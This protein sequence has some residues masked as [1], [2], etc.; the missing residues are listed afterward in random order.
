MTKLLRKIKCPSVFFCLTTIAALCL[1]LPDHTVEHLAANTR[2]FT[3]HHY[4]LGILHLITYQFMHANLDHFKYNFLFA[5]APCIYLE[6]R[7]KSLKFLLFYL[8]A[9]IISALVFIVAMQHSDVNE[10]FEAMGM[11]INLVGASGSIYGCMMLASL[12]WGIENIYNAILSLMFVLFFVSQQ[13]VLAITS[14]HQP[15]SVAYWGHV[16]G[17]ISAFLV[18]P[19]FLTKL[20]KHAK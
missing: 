8:F 1:L 5:L 9:G 10:L 15:V 11:G 20:R 18:L 2:D 19:L 13:I 3:D 4:L 16:G 14:L 7:L 17:I 12:L 6:K